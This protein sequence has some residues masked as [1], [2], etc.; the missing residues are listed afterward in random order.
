MPDGKRKETKM[1]KKQNEKERKEGEIKKRKD[2]RVSFPQIYGGRQSPWRKEKGQGRKGK[3]TV[4][5]SCKT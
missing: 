4:D 2:V 3:K 5:F 1:A